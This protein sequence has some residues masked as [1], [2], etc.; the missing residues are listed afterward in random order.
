[1]YPVISRFGGVGQE[2]KTLGK[3]HRL[4]FVIQNHRTRNRDHDAV[5]LDSRS[6]LAVAGDDLMLDFLER[7]FD[8]FLEDG[9]GAHDRGSLEGHHAVFFLRNWRRTDG[10]MEN[11]TF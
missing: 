8:E 7:E 5:R 11:L 1:M 9:I 6:G 4:A 2:V 10:R 3:L